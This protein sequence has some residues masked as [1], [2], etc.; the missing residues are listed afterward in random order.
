MGVSLKVWVHAM[1][2]PHDMLFVFKP[3]EL[4]ALNLVTT[5]GCACA[6]STV[7]VWLLGIGLASRDG[8]LER[9]HPRYVV[10][11]DR[12]F[13]DAVFFWELSSVRC[14]W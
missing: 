10:R 2:T 7:V 11:C 5:D 9:S 4:K 1:E 14:C 8:K 12:S 6:K 3:D 13:V